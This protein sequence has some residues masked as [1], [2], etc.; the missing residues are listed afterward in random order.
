MFAGGSQAGFY[1]P[2]GDFEV[3]GDTQGT[4]NSQNS[5]IGGTITFTFTYNPDGTSQPPPQFVIYRIFTEAGTSFN[6]AVANISEASD[7]DG[8]GDPEVLDKVQNGVSSS[9]S[10]NPNSSNEGYH[11]LVVQN[12]G[13]SF[14]ETIQLSASAVGPL[15]SGASASNFVEAIVS[16]DMPPTIDVYAAP[17]E[18]GYPQIIEGQRCEAEVSGNTWDAKSAVVTVQ[19]CN[20]VQDIPI[21]YTKPYAYKP[22]NGGNAVLDGGGPIFVFTQ[23]DGSEKPHIGSSWWNATITA[24]FNVQEDSGPVPLSVS[25]N[26]QVQAPASYYGLGLKFSLSYL[27]Q[28]ALNALEQAQ[29]G[30][31][32]LDPIGTNPVD[33]WLKL[34]N[35]GGTANPEYGMYGIYLYGWVQDPSIAAQESVTPG[36][37]FWIQTFVDGSTY[38]TG[39]VTTPFMPSPSSTYEDYLVEAD[40]LHAAANSQHMIK[41]DFADSPGFNLSLIGAQK[42]TA[43]AEYETYLMYTPPDIAS[44]YPSLDV[45]VAELT[46]TALGGAAFN[47]LAWTPEFGSSF[48]SGSS[49]N[50]DPV[51][52][53][54]LPSWS[55]VWNPN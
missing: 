17:V 47:N 11:D 7:N 21:D 8:F 16:A 30:L 49:L 52:Q 23:D 33:D 36:R 41:P 19:G 55:L 35:A 2:Y 22:F 13:K 12:P 26:V 15:P 27:N 39:G 32:S 43:S 38:S 29:M 5:P 42:V 6:G 4:G 46:W 48:D 37:Y 54:V 24:A 3:Y 34:M 1:L 28:Q 14:T 44:G 31:E 20:P 25:Q 53:I 9:K 51:S 18:G 50:L 45:P 40:G 10:N